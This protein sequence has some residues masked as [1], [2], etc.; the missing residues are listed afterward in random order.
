MDD[1]SFLIPVGFILLFG[2]MVY[3]VISRQRNVAQENLLRAARLG[4]TPLAQAEPDLIARLARLRH[5]PDD[6]KA[7]LKNIFTR[8]L[9]DGSLYLF[10]LESTTNGDSSSLSENVILVHT[11]S[12]HLPRFSLFP[13]LANWG[14]ITGSFFEKVIQWALERSN[15]VMIPV[16]PSR[17]FSEKVILLA[18]SVE[19]VRGLVESGLLERLAITENQHIEA[20]G[21]MFTYRKLRF[22]HL[23]SQEQTEALPD[24]IDQAQRILTILEGYR[25]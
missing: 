4:L 11:S 22:P 14:G 5:F 24:L 1:L 6:E 18:E 3:W 17:S 16:E 12:L 21:D 19:A 13:N 15:L 7:S 10:D 23:S 9:P 8:R 2:L 20:E 25:G